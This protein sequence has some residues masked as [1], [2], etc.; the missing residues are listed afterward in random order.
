VQCP[1]KAEGDAG[2]AAAVANFYDSNVS[3][4]IQ[5]LLLKRNQK[6]SLVYD[7]A[8]AGATI[9]QTA[10]NDII[11]QTDATN[12]PYNLATI[13]PTC[14]AVLGGTNDA[15]SIVG[16]LDSA[17]FETDYKLILDNIIV[18]GVQAIV[19]CSIPSM[20]ADP[21]NTDDERQA[22]L[23]VNTA[24]DSVFSQYSA[25]NPS[26]QWGFVD[27]YTLMGGANPDL[28]LFQ[29]NNI[30]P[31]ARGHWFMGEWIEAELSRIFP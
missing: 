13:D 25:A 31:N 20:D 1:Y 26:I 15:N 18:Q 6:E 14:V 28:S 16:T 12:A 11:D 29:T 30:H 24:I 17:L 8:N 23:D 9:I 19:M 4:R 22:T 3:T 10:T 5:N 7:V 21:S 27:L 2:N